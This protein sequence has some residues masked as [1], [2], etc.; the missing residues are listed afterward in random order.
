MEILLINVSEKGK[1][2]KEKRKKLKKKKKIN[3]FESGL[4]ESKI[5]SL[6]RYCQR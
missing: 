5:K 3:R 4:D 6:V 2:K 1:R